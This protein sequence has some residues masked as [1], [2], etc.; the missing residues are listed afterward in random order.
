M[1]LSFQ[2][3]L[4][5]NLMRQVDTLTQQ[6]NQLQEQLKAQAHAKPE[7]KAKGATLAN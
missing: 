2:E 4:I 1:N 7:P 6:V 5:I 3:V